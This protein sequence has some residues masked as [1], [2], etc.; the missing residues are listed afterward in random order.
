MPII[1]ITGSVH[2]PIGYYLPSA[3]YTVQLSNFADTT[4]HFAVFTDSTVFSVERRR[5]NS[6][7]SDKLAFEN[8]GK[9]FSL[10]NHNSST[11]TYD[12]QFIASGS[13]YE[14]VFGINECEISSKDSMNIRLDGKNYLKITNIGK[15]K[16]YNLLVRLASTRADL[17]FE[18]KNIEMKGAAVHRIEPVWENIAKQPV[19][20]SIDNNMDGVWD[21]IRHVENQY[22]P[23]TPS[24][25]G[26]LSN[27]NVYFYPNPF[28]PDMEIGTIRYSLGR[29]GNVSI[30]IYDAA[31]ALVKTLIQDV[32]NEA[33]IE[34]SARWDGRNERGEI[35][36]NGVYFYVI[37]SSAGE[38]AIGKAAVLR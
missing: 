27:K 3:S 1:P 29:S 10:V 28:N 8:G 37:E 17:I 19:T 6:S 4:M 20:I 5:T 16:K 24:T 2:P 21:E 11:K 13:G 32:P 9:A 22:K 30:K 38:K 12:T 15:P 26:E 36:A 18:H 35:V 34:R 31:N 7:E 25:G 14:R 33:G 23:Q